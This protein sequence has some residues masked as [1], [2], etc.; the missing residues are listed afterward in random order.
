MSFRSIRLCPSGPTIAL[1]ADHPVV[2][3]G[4][5][6][7]CQQSCQSV[8]AAAVYICIK[9]KSLHDLN[10]NI[11]KLWSCNA[12]LAKVVS[13][14]CPHI[15]HLKIC[16]FD[17]P[18]IHTNPYKSHKWCQSGNENERKNEWKWIKIKANCFFPNFQ[19]CCVEV[20]LDFSQNPSSKPAER[21]AV[22]PRRLQGQRRQPVE[23]QCQ[24]DCLSF[25]KK[26]NEVQKS[27]DEVKTRFW[28]WNR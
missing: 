13:E 2:G 15:T 18:Q 3:V 19:N 7:L 22:D 11:T 5:W 14:L 9:F 23:A 10:S 8:L 4:H 25:E 28:I 16:T 21:A 24:L 17:I 20:M 26:Q 27:K 1:E 6:V 12:I